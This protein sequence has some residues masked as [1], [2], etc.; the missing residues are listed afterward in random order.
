MGPVMLAVFL[1]GFPGAG[2]E[3]GS[4]EILY[5]G[6]GVCVRSETWI[7]HLRCGPWTW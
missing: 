6:G 4:S 5:D 2:S 1:I 7:S 3:V